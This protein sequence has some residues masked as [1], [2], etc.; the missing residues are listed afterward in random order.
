MG[1]IQPTLSLHSIPVLFV[2]KKDGSLCLCID[3]HSLNCISKKDCYLLLL[4]S[5]LLDLSYKDWVYS[6]IDLHHA[7]HLVHIA[8]GDEW[9]TVFRTC[10]GSFEWSIMPFSFTNA[11]AAFQ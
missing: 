1:F 7:Y 6:K 8:A 5:D 3:F 2:K 4:I 9:K 11:L 10:Y